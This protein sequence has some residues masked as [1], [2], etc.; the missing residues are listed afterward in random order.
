VRML[1]ILTKCINCCLCC[2]KR[3]SGF[4]SYEDEG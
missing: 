2:F 1:S 4:A 3:W